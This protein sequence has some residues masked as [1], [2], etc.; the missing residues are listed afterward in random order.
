MKISTIIDGISTDCKTICEVMT[1]TGVK[2]AEFQSCSG[3]RIEENTLDEARAYKKL[4]DEYG[5]TPSCVT[6]HAFAGVPITAV[7]VGD[8]IY[9]HHMSL[10]KNGIEIARI[11]GCK[12]VRTMAFTKTIVTFGKNGADKWNAGNNTAWPKFLELFAPIAKL[13]EDEDIDILVEPCFNSMITSCWLFK[14]MVEDLGAKRIKLLWD[15]CNNLYYHEY[16]TLDVY[17]SIKPYLAHIHIKDGIIDSVRSTNE[18]RAIGTGM[19]APYLLDLADALRRD[20]YQG[21]IS[22]ENVF[23]PEGKDFR[24]GYYIDI[25]SLKRIFG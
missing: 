8:E 10:L 13:A 4:I 17:E 9:Q 2:Y 15:P 5:I 1:K 25:E 21:C 19:M 3:R 18:F 6:T 12:Q 20:D 24:D 11:L 16:P 22:L 23:R 7:E 14:K